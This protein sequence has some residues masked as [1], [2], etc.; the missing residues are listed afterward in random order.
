MTNKSSGHS[1]LS[2]SQPAGG[3][4]GGQQNYVSLPPP[5]T[6][7]LLSQS[8]STNRTSAPANQGP[9]GGL[10]GQGPGGGQNYGSLPPPNSSPNTTGRGG[11]LG[12]TTGGGAPS[13]G[14]PPGG[15]QTYTALPGP[16]ASPQPSNGTSHGPQR[17]NSAVGS[18]NYGSLP[19]PPAAGVTRT[20][21]AVQQKSPTP[22]SPD[23][24]KK[25]GKDKDK[26]K[27]KGKPP[28]SNYTQLPT[29]VK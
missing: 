18:A 23:D 21:S 27:S 4:P 25:K 12:I 7:S 14:A 10:L 11:G 16:G 20:A 5:V 19:T 29:P 15:G 22:S 6:P 9:P 1:Q 2:Q 13:S 24:K 26:G 3:P 28:A 17:T 8:V